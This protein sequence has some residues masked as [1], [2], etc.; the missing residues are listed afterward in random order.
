MRPYD[1]EMGAL[2]GQTEI[3][4]F[5]RRVERIRVTG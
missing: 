2:G 4:A 1:L 5:A 3:E